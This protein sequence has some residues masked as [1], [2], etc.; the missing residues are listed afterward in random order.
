LI[1]KGMKINYFIVSTKLLV[2]GYDTMYRIA[3][4]WNLV[5]TDEKKCQFSQKVTKN[6]VMTPKRQIAPHLEIRVADA[7]TYSF[8][9]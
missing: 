1:E 2:P 3:V 6:Q 9:E 7:L 8:Y 5:F 4:P